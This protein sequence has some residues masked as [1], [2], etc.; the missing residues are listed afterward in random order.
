MD[1][2]ND[3]YGDVESI[4]EDI[5]SDSALVD[6]PAIS[7]PQ[8][9]TT[10]AFDPSQV[11]ETVYDVAKGVRSGEVD[12]VLEALEKFKKS[13]LIRM[14]DMTVIGPV[15]IWYAYK[16]KLS[17][18]ERTLLGVIGAS[19]ILYNYRNWLSNK[20]NLSIR[21]SDLNLSGRR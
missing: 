21:E 13:Q 1:Y 9:F 10:S 4:S 19:T 11:K 7:I 14:L 12:V 15:M 6:A 16:G 18:M 17:M 5:Q 8:N 20:V 2:D 3:Q